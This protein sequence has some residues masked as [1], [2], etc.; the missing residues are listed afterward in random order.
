[1]S[2]PKPKGLDDRYARQFADASVVESYQHRRPYP[3]E[4]IQILLGL[5]GNEPRRVLDIACGR[6]EIARRMVPHVDHVD[7]VDRSAGMIEAGKK[8]AEGNNPKL[9]WICAAVEEAPLAGP[10]G[11]MVAA[12]SLHWMDWHV[13]LP[14]LGGVL[15]DG[16]VLAIFNDDALP[17][18]WGDELGRLIPLYSTNQDFEPYDLVQELVTRELFE[19]RG[20]QT[21]SP[22]S[23]RQRIDDYVDSIHSQNG[24]SRERMS[25]GAAAEF[26]DKVRA[27][28]SPHAREGFLELHPVT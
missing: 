27:I 28:V 9:R 6:G 3:D 8:L 11:L 10:Y 23:F 17:V 12:S 13:V 26:D 22:I 16:G 25:A 21:T 14:R 4:V 18:P 20:S 15:S 24:F 19:V 5:L 7:A 1:M 2:H